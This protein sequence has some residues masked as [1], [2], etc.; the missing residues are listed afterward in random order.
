[1]YVWFS[2][3]A[4][5]L[6]VNRFYCRP[7]IASTTSWS[8]L[9]WLQEALQSSYYSTKVVTTITS[10]LSLGK[11][12]SFMFGWDTQIMSGFQGKAGNAPCWKIN[13]LQIM[14]NPF[15]GP[16][17]KISN[18]WGWFVGHMTIWDPKPPRNPFGHNCY[19]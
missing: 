3:H 6:S 16:A 1:M 9:M 2:V 17:T 19:T 11:S 14:L 8:R 10:S 15:H 13:S 5:N 18:R 4:C 7:P 12:M